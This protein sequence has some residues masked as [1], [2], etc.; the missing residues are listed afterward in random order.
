MK[1]HTFKVLSRKE[2]KKKRSKAYSFLYFEKVSNSTGSN[3]APDNSKYENPL[4]IAG[5]TGCIGKMINEDE[6]KR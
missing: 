5:Y 1:K 2:I 3:Q 6:S 4:D